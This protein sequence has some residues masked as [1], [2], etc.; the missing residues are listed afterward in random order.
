MEQKSLAAEAQTVELAAG[1][2]NSIQSELDHYKFDVETF[3][4]QRESRDT[5]LDELFRDFVLKM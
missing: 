2:A 4:V 5:D 1:K 3:P